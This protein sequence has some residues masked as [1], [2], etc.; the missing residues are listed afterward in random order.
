MGGEIRRVPAS[1]GNPSQARIFS[2]TYHIEH[3]GV[4]LLHFAQLQ[5]HLSSGSGFLHPALLHIV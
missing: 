3:A 5:P 2:S 1:I 4:R